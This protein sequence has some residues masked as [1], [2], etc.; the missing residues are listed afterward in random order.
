MCERDCILICLV[1]LVWFYSRWNHE[2]D[3]YMGSLIFHRRKMT[4]IP[5]LGI[6]STGFK[7][8]LMMLWKCNSRE[9]FN[10]LKKI[11]FKLIRFPD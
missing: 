1:L 4:S 7:K 11:K 8:V 3:L 9:T 10:I 6:F 5:T 2:L